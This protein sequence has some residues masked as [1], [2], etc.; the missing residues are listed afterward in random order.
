MTPAREALVEIRGLLAHDSMVQAVRLGGSLKR[1]EDDA[2][3]DLDLWI[4]AE[5]G[6]HPNRLG[7]LWLGGMEGMLGDRPFFH[8][9]LASGAVVDFL[10]G[11]EPWPGYD[12]LDAVPP[13]A[14]TDSE[15]GE[16]GLLVEAWINT[17]KHEKV[18]ARGLWP[19]GLIGMEIDRKY[20][21][22]LWAMLATGEDP[23]KG[24]FTIH[25]LTPIVRRDLT[26]ERTALLGLP[27]RTEG[28][29]RETLSALRQELR[30]VSVALGEKG[31]PRPSR[32]ESVVLPV[33]RIEP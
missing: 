17:Y 9:I 2:W 29:L 3:S 21:V 15:P 10:V 6:W 8:G 27:A 33:L 7:S 14:P 4:D 18:I 26:P 32:I 16:T 11:P 20:L 22:R 30:S 13:Q 24:A 5:D 25:G 23:G 28:E 1:N 31:R 19:M 12:F